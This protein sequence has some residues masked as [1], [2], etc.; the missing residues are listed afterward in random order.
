MSFPRPDGPQRGS[1]RKREVA[2]A[3]ARFQGRPRRIP[4]LGKKFHKLH[5]AAA[6]REHD[7]RK[8]L[9]EHGHAVEL[10]HGDLSYSNDPGKALAQAAATIDHLKSAH[11]AVNQATRDAQDDTDDDVEKACNRGIRE[12]FHGTVRR[13]R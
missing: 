10:E 5:E 1:N 6:E 13:P 7:L 2:L 8:T 11:Q 3:R 9:M 12:Q 4:K